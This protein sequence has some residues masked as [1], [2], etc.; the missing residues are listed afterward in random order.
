MTMNSSV[1]KKAGGDMIEQDVE[2]KSRRECCKGFFYVKK[3]TFTTH[4]YL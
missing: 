4:I 2:E 1:Y 3:T